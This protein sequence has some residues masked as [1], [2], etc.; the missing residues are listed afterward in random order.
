MRRAPRTAHRRNRP[1]LGLVPPHPR[2]WRRAVHRPARPLRP[3][4]GCRRSRQPGFQGC[5]EAALGMGGADRRQGAQASGRN[6]EPGNADRHDRSLH[7]R[8]R[9]A[10]TGRRSA[11]AG[12]RRSGISGRDPAEISLPRSAARAAAQEHH[13][14][15]A[16]DRLDPPPDEGGRLL[17]IPDADPH[18]IVAGRRAR[19]SRS[20][21]HPSRKILRAAAGAAAIQTADHGVGLRPLFPDRAMFP[22]RGRARRPFARRIL[23]ARYGNELRDTAG[24]VRGGRAG[25][26]RRVRGIRERQAGDAEISA[27]SLRRGIAPLRHRQAGSAQ[28]DQDGECERSL[29][30]FGL[31]DFR[32]HARRR[33]E[34]RKS[35]RSRRRPAAIAPSATG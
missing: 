16:G 2:P 8:D 3:H 34:S 4:A 10:G 13:A 7:F 35:G 23:S 5:R 11:D 14:A 29:P 21:A 30:R 31:Q 32:G 20:L 28:P 26:A 15:R 25:D 12:I 19:L 17:R 24:R 9:G 6:R 18:G 27:H 33:S 1:A 22:R